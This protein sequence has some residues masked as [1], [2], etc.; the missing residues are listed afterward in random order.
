MLI[1]YCF[2]EYIAMQRSFDDIH[3][4]FYAD[5]LRKQ[6]STT[7]ESPWT[8]VVESVIQ[9][10]ELITQAFLVRIES[11]KVSRLKEAP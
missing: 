10:G 7:P 2:D 11:N 3:K 6:A 9:N 8:L 4:H 5:N 1:P